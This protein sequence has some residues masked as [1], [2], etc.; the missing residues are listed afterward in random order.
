MTTTPQMRPNMPTAL[1][2]QLK[3]LLL[4][5]LYD[6]LFEP[7]ARLALGDVRC[8][9]LLDLRRRLEI[10]MF[11][12]SSGTQAAPVNRIGGFPLA[13]SACCFPAVHLGRELGARCSHI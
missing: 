13:G 6:R 3:P 11:G 1:R 2:I 4:E 10:E 7:K 12:A 9:G 8:Q 5:L